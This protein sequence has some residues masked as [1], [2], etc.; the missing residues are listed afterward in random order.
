MKLSEFRKIID[1]F[2]DEA[3]EKNKEDDN[4]VLDIDAD[5]DR[6][7]KIG[8]GDIFKSRMSKNTV[9]IEPEEQIEKPKPARY[10]LKDR[11]IIIDKTNYTCPNCGFRIGKND[12]FCR[13]CGQK[14]IT[15]KEQ[16]EEE[17]EDRKEMLARHK[18][19]RREEREA[20]KARRASKRKSLFRRK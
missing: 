20:R 17:Y 1:A 5:K 8:I 9:K 16:E 11:D 3:R 2:D 12:R 13:N 6:E 4:V 18:I 10:I 7:V 14:L 15:I 19:E